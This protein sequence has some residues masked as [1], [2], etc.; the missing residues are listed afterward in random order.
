MIVPRPRS[1][2]PTPAD[3]DALADQRAEWIQRNQYYYDEIE[4]LA[5]FVI[6]PGLRVLEIG[7]GLGDLLASVRPS[8][9]MGIDVS[10]KMVDRAKARHP[11]LHFKVARAEEH[12]ESEAYDAIILSDV[13][14]HLHDVWAAFRNARR[15]CAAHT[16]VFVTFYNF[17]WEPILRVG[18]W[19][20]L[21]MPLA[22]QNW[23]SGADLANLLELAGFE[24]VTRG[25]S[26]LV[27]RRLPLISWVAN[28][29]LAHTG[30]L[31][32]L[33]LLDYLVARPEQTRTVQERSV[34]VVIPCRN[35]RGNIH[36]AV[37][38]TPDLGLGTEIVF[39]DGNSD[40]GTQEAI[41]E[42][43]ERNPHRRILL[44]DQGAGLGKGD[45]VRKG[46]AASRGEILMILDADLTV[47]PEDLP[48]F[49]NALVEGRG[50]LVNGS[51]L[52]YPMEAG[53]MR[54]L[55][56]FGNKFFSVALSWILAQPIRDTL[57]GTKTL[58]ASDYRRVADQRAFFG[59]FDPF[60][61]FDLIFGAAKA[62]LKIREIPVRYRARTYGETKISRFRHG[63][64]LLRM[65]AF[66]LR[67][68]K[69]ASLKVDDGS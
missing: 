12:I 4:R 65:T 39:V 16:R 51:R 22:E 11:G 59:D 53:A 52:V 38:R 55:N 32:H 63:F 67:K 36:E 34:S 10:P 54:L 37:E 26:L 9:G 57:C 3:F 46:F 20:G 49:Y 17:L 2:R 18:E 69:M 56:I 33:A 48:K 8:Y 66:A 1:V 25:S 7:S 27:P 29:L 13:V 41:R 43:I 35:E 14:G 58:L 47:P 21:K 15:A 30:P 60:G 50:E 42:E 44:I 61:D 31:R 62:G 28:R 6:P 40:D 23:L 64:L 5:R 19:I 45:A 24:V 68:F